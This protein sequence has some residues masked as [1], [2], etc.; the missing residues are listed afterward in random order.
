MP[1]LE[2]LEQDNY[3]GTY[4]PTTVP[5]F[6]NIPWTTLSPQINLTLSYTAYVDKDGRHRN[7]D[8]YS[9]NTYTFENLILTVTNESSGYFNGNI[10]ARVFSGDDTTDIATLYVSPGYFKELTYNFGNLTVTGVTEN[11][12]TINV[13]VQMYT[14]APT[15]GQRSVQTHVGTGARFLTDLSKQILHDSGWRLGT[16]VAYWSQYNKNVF[17]IA[18]KLLIDYY[19]NQPGTFWDARWSFDSITRAIDGAYIV[20]QPGGQ[21]LKFGLG[22]L[23]LSQQIMGKVSRYNDRMLSDL[24]IK[25]DKDTYGPQTYSIGDRNGIAGSIDVS[26]GKEYHLPEEL[27]LELSRYGKDFIYVSAT[28]KD[29]YSPDP[30]WEYKVELREYGVTDP[31]YTDIVDDT[32]RFEQNYSGQFQSGM[33]ESDES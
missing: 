15:T 21:S 29:N 17:G 23:N 19:A 26:A 32:G 1:E 4:T 8:M 3:T 13:K 6:D 20:R 16:S 2:E 18:D 28:P 24:F 14:N 12:E 30:R 7:R 5:I 9:P 22:Q 10:R 27:E 31:I 25:I 11:V 33:K